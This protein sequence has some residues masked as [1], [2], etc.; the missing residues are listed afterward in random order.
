MILMIYGEVY[1]CRNILIYS[2]FLTTCNFNRSESKYSPKHLVLK[3]PE[4][5]IFLQSCTPVQ[6]NGSYYSPVHF[7]VYILFGG[8]LKR[9]LL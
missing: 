6:N 5:I 7:N 2:T 3:T 1:V 8:R 9:S 4:P